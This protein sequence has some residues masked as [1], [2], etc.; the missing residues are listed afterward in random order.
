MP[1]LGCAFEKLKIKNAE[2]FKKIQTDLKSLYAEYFHWTSNSFIIFEEFSNS[3][4]SLHNPSPGK[5]T[6]VIVVEPF[7]SRITGL[8]NDFLW[9]TSHGPPILWVHHLFISSDWC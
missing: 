7:F 1:R 5:I 8:R 6:T 9:E 2:E 4:F 3:E